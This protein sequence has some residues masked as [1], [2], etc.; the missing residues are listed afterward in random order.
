MNTRFFLILIC[1]VSLA[2][3]LNIESELKEKPNIN[4]PKADF[5]GHNFGSWTASRVVVYFLINIMTWV[6]S[7]AIPMGLEFVCKDILKW[8][9]EYHPVTG[10]ANLLVII[11]GLSPT[12][13]LSIIKKYHKEHTL[14]EIEYYVQFNLSQDYLKL[15]KTGRLFYRTNFFEL[16]YIFIKFVIILMG[17]WLGMW[18]VQVDFIAWLQ[19]SLI[20]SVLI[21]YGFMS[22]IQGT[23]S[24]VFTLFSNDYK[25]GDIIFIRSYDITGFIVEFGS[26]RTKLGTVN[27]PLLKKIVEEEGLLQQKTNNAAQT[28]GQVRSHIGATI[29][30]YG[31]THGPEENVIHSAYLNDVPIFI[32][33][34]QTNNY[35]TQTREDFNKRN[36][37]TAS[38]T[39]DNI[40]GNFPNV[41]THMKVKSGSTAEAYQSLLIYTHIPNI[42][43]WQ[44]VVSNLSC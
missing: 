30:T 26:F 24:Q 14:D 23:I 22:F 33:L 40:Q 6:L 34:P 42:T 11:F 18:V 2:E 38:G 27:V 20:N 39:Y 41:P 29:Q 16:M 17:T 21:L 10:L 3:Y 8:H 7:S 5:L 4:I 36:V 1:G 12:E 43:F 9:L 44:N 35:H 28:T 15:K 31:N 32:P 37:N 25:N 19:S 13:A